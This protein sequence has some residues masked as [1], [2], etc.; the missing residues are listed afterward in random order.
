MDEKEWINKI[1][2]FMEDLISDRKRL[3]GRPEDQSTLGWAW[4]ESYSRYAKF[5]LLD[6]PD[7][8]FDGL[9]EANKRRFQKLVDTGTIED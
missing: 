4:F 9:S 3:E 7:E 8:M 2:E 5:H 1:V 6:I